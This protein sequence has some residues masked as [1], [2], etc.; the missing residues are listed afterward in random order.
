MSGPSNFLR[1]V[2]AE[3]QHHKLPSFRII[4]PHP[5]RLKDLYNNDVVKVGRLDGTVFYKLTSINLY[6]LIRQRRER[7][8]ELIKSIPDFMTLSLNGP[9]NSY[10]NRASGKILQKA[11]IIIFQSEL[12]RK[13]HQ[14]F[15]GDAKQQS[16][17][18]LNGVPVEIFNPDV[19]SVSLEGSP[20]LAITA[21]FRL[22]KRL[23]NA[24]KLTNNLRKKLP[25]ITLH[26][27][28]VIDDLTKELIQSLDLSSCIFHGHVSSSTLP[29]IYVGCDLGLSPSLFDPCPNSVVEMVSCGLP[30][31]T[32]SAS[33]AAE[34]IKNPELIITEDLDFDFMELQTAEAISEIDIPA[35]S[36]AVV[37]ALDNRI[38]LSHSMLR[39]VEEE[40]DIKIVAERY[41]KAINGH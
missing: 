30:V 12:S 24:I 40:I 26:V 3:L 25:S 38:E 32:T 34:I 5:G 23:Q 29:S 18:I 21:S 2:N 36:E 39:R 6:N 13:M 22:H 27:M 15:F 17:V 14:R 1:R 37:S 19:K 31:L 28:G 8:I 35:W 9:I 16:Y 33:G 4:N 10:L 11:D 20:R 7:R 41:A